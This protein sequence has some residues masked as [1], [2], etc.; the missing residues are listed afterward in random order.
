MNNSN[1]LSQIMY[2]NNITYRELSK[3]SDI[4]ISALNN[5][6]NF[7]KEPRQSTMIAIARALD[8][9]VVE[10]FDLDWRN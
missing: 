6:A 10:I 2:E 7:E 1:I 9:D 8:M 4:S 5:I 3:L